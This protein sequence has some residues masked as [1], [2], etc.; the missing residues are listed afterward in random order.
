MAEKC[1]YYVSVNLIY[2]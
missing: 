1:A 2:I